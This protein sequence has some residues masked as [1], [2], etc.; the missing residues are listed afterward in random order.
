MHQ[1]RPA[2]FPLA[3]NTFLLASAL[4]LLGYLLFPVAPPRLAG[5]GVKDTI[6]ADHI[7]LNG[8]LISSLYNPYA[9]VPSMHIAYSLIVAVSVYRFGRA[10]LVRSLAVFYPPLMLL[11]VV[12]TGNHFVFDA[13]AGA[14]V[15]WIAGCLGTVMTR[16]GAAIRSVSLRMTA[17]SAAVEPG[18][19]NGGFG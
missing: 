5:I 3:R 12:A 14:L 7:D 15:A 13:A 19:S 6:S 18:D 8:G 4:A 17:P 11:V 9:A 10:R 1:R 16:R 2:A